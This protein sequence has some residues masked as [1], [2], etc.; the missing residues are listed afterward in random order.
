MHPT[1]THIPTPSSKIALP[2]HTLQILQ[3]FLLKGL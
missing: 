3:L 2:Q 1:H